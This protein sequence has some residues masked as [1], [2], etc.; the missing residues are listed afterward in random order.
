MAAKSLEAFVNTVQHYVLNEE[1]RVVFLDHFS[2]LADGIALNVDQR[3]AIDKAIKDL[4][5]L[6]MELKFTFVV[7]C[8]LSR[9]QGL[10]QSHEEGGEP[11][12]SELRGSHSLAQ[13]PDYIWMLAR[14]PLDKEQPQHN[15]MLAKEEQDQGRSG[16]EGKLEFEPRVAN[17]QELSA[18]T[19]Y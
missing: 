2:L 3:R 7:V 8:H 19:P 14:N 18:T 17:S 10:A 16:H 11:K 9:A 5:T 13:I 4:K 12:L 6:A 1:C 15:I